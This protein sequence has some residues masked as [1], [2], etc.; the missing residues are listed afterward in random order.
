MLTKK[1]RG[2]CFVFY[3][4]FLRSRKAS[5]TPTTI[6]ATIMPMTAGTKYASERGVGLAVGAAVAGGASITPKV[7]SAYEA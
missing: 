7:V 5:N 6:I 1:K 2:E 3:A 4:R